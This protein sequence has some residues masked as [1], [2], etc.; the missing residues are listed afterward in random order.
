MIISKVDVTTAE[1]LPGA[2]IEVTDRD[3]NRIFTGISDENGKVY[4]PVPAPG[5]YHFKELT[6]PE[7]YDRNETV[8]SF[9]VFEDGSII[10]DNTITDQK[11]YGTIT[12]SYEAKRNGEGDLTVGELTHAPKTGDT[13]R[14]ALLFAAWAASAVCLISFF[15]YHRRKKHRKSKGSMKAGLFLLLAVL[16]L[17][18]PTMK[19]E[20]ADDVIENIYEEHQYTTENP[21]SDEAE[22]MFKKEIERDGTKYRLSEIGQRWL[23]SRGPGKPDVPLRLPRIR[24]LTERQR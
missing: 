4:F 18:T 23:R 19:A 11:H 14:L 24:F 1:E 9:T 8:F 13:S 10:G 22:K 20:A 6:A 3:G 12:A 2:E 16:A 7:G 21:D 17:G 5:E 15:L